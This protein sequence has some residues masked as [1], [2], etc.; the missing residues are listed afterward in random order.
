MFCAEVFILILLKVLLLSC[1][2]LV[3]S[4]G[5]L[6]PRDSFTRTVCGYLGKDPKENLCVLQRC[7]GTSSQTLV[8]PVR[9]RSTYTLCTPYVRLYKTTYFSSDL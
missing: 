5:G 6:S 8:N 4:P 3:F 9:I 2:K 7:D 1:Q